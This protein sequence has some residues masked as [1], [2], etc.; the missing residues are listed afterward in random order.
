[1]KKIA[2][3]IPLLFLNLTCQEKKDTCTCMKEI[4]REKSKSGFD[5]IKAQMYPK[6]CK[7]LESQ[8]EDD[9]LEALDDACRQELIIILTENNH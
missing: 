8:Q 3:L 1:M 7:Y 5:P 6:G 4:A 2:L 9:I